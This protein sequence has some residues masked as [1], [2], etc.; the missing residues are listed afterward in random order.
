[1][2]SYDCFYIIFKSGI[3]SDHP[4]NDREEKS[5][6]DLRYPPCLGVVSIVGDVKD[7]RKVLMLLNLDFD[8]D[9]ELFEAEFY[10]ILC[11]RKIKGADTFGI[12][13]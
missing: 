1:M 4:Y 11:L 2:L 7:T 9:K 8:N 5:I 3:E 10:E 12:R 13:G 6:K